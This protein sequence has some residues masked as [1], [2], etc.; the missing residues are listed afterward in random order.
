MGYFL[1]GS[2]NGKGRIIFKSGDIYDG[3]LKN[4]Y[5]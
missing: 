3:L 4:G 5:F 2:L 1:N